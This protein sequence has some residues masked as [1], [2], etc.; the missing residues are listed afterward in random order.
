M[1]DTVMLR[2]F[3]VVCAAVASIVLGVVVLVGLPDNSVD[4]LAG[5]GIAAGSGLLVLLL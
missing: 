4:L 2:K 5:M 1:N 3:F